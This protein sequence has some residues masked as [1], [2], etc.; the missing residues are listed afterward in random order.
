MSLWSPSAPRVTSCRLHGQMGQMGADSRA[1][2]MSRFAVAMLGVVVAVAC[3]MGWQLFR[4]VND[5]QVEALKKRGYPMTLVE[6]DEWYPWPPDKENAALVYTNVF[7]NQSFSNAAWDFSGRKWPARGEKIEP[8]ELKALKELMATNQEALGLLLTAATMPSSRYPIDLKQGF[9]S[10]FLHLAPVKQGAVFLC[11]AALVWAQEG[12]DAKAADALISAGRLADSLAEEPTLIS[13]LVRYAAWGVWC[14]RVERIL[15]LEKL[16]DEQLTRLQELAAGAD[17]PGCLARGLGGETACGY[18]FFSNSKQQIDLLNQGN[19]QSAFAPTKPSWK[20]GIQ[21]GAGIWLLK[22]SGFFAKD[23]A[24]YLDSMATN[25]T[26]AEQSYPERFKANQRLG[27]IVSPS[28]FMLFSSMLLPAL[29]KATLR[30]AD[31]TARV[32]VAAAAIAVERFRR[33]NTNSLPKDLGQLTP[34]FL[35]AV[36]LDPFDGQPLRFKR[37]GEGYVVY[38][39]GSDGHDDGG[40]GERPAGQSVRAGSLRG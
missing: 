13:Q 7:A 22:L 30:D 18:A 9:L 2:R 5:P 4:P 1:F 6:L 8:E 21:Y 16:N 39:V 28:R 23:R 37:V 12:E 40:A 35:A 14:S 20:D 34:A 10:L 3:F 26:I 33:A 24:F 25:L 19:L 11:G 17:K 31:H 36:P 15:N 38:S 27:I 29:S 32:R